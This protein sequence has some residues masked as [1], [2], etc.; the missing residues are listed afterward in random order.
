VKLSGNRMGL[1]VL[2]PINPA[3]VM[4]RRANRRIAWEGIEAFRA[5][6]ENVL[7]HG[8]YLLMGGLGAVE[9]G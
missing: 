4:A 2:E 1:D 8:P 7:R 6:F 3:L 9:M 5:V